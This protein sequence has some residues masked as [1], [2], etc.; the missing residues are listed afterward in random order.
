MSCVTYSSS[1]MCLVFYIIYNSAELPP[2]IVFMLYDHLITLDRDWTIMWQSR[3][4]ASTMLLCANRLATWGW[5]FY[6]V[7]PMTDKVCFSPISM[8]ILSFLITMGRRKQD[9]TIPRTLSTISCFLQ[10]CCQ[11]CR[12]AK[13]GFAIPFNLRH[14]WSVRIDL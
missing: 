12:S 3:W 1:R 14:G 11:I 5:A 10:M 2:C 8:P 13:W 9:F 6:T 7:V 4:T